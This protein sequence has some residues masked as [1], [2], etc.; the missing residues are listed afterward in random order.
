[1]AIYFNKTCIGTYNYHSRDGHT[2]KVEM[3][4]GNCDSIHIWIDEKNEAHLFNFISNNEHLKNIEKDKY[5]IFENCTDIKM[6]SAYQPNYKLMK[7]ATKNKH[8]VTMYYEKI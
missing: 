3:R 7:Y 2:Y 1:M 5:D 4:G 6:N 8:E